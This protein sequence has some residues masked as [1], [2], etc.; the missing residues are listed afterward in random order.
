MR[1]IF[2]IFNRIKVKE[3]TY[4]LGDSYVTAI[5]DV[6]AG[7]QTSETKIL[8][9]HTDLNRIIAKI[10]SMGYEFKVEKVNHFDFGDGT[11]LVDYSFEN[12]FGQEITLTD[13][14]FNKSI[15]K[16]RA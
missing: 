3:V 1:T 16:I 5:C 11:E 12:V 6:T 10:S 8:M 7:G 14:Q 13:F 15:Q 2:S 4:E 9:S